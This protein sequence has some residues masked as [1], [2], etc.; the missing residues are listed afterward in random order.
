MEIETSIFGPSGS[1][2]NWLGSLSSHRELVRLLVVR[3]LKVRYKRSV[4]GFFW[5]LLN[6]VIQI[7]I[8]SVV[9]SRLFVSFYHQ[10]KIY[11]ISGVLLWSFFSLATSQGLFSMIGNGSTI[12]R[13]AV[14]KFVFP[15]SVVC[16]NFV[17][18]LFS[19]AALAIAI[20]FVGGH[21]SPALIWLLVGLPLLFG[22]T[23]GVAL[24]LSTLTVFVRDMRSIWE[25]LLL[26]WFF[27]T[28]VFYPR[29]VIPEKYDSVLRF[30][31]MLILLDIC[32]IPID[33]G[34]TPPVG[35]FLKAGLATVCSLWIGVWVFK[36]YEDK[37]IYYV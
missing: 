14:P 16:S 27:L 7:V 29:T 15:L 21:F 17:N 36:R 23:L 11:M 25:P 18:L 20:P 8:F 35:T 34:L 1:S 24:L 12:R 26:I 5:T 37:F 22:F 10:Y 19:L 28:P 6:P 3:D 31:P 9:F 32:R 2:K 13:M 33:I 30:N 4:L